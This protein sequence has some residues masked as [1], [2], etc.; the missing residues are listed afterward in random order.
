MGNWDYKGYKSE[1]LAECPAGYPP[2]G[3]EFEV[4]YEPTLSNP[5]RT[6]FL[7]H[8]YG[9]EKQIDS[10][11]NERISVRAHPIASRTRYMIGMAVCNMGHVH[12]TFDGD[13]PEGKPPDC[14]GFGD[15]TEDECAYIKSIDRRV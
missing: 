9:W 5:N 7:H 11:G 3:Y 8:V 14:W 4:Q 1:R 12:P 2:R 10:E 15:M 13:E 6:V